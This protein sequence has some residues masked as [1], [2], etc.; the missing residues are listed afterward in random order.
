[1]SLITIV[2][3]TVGNHISEFPVYYRC[4]RGERDNLEKET[5]YIP[6]YVCFFL[7]SLIR[8]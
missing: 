6:R 8:H 3:F 5:L 2:Q 1:V 7:L 4:I